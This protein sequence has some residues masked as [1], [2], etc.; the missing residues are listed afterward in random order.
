ML[1]LPALVVSFALAVAAARPPVVAADAQRYGRGVTTYIRFPGY[2]HFFSGRD[3]RLTAEDRIWTGRMLDFEGANNRDEAILLLW[4]MIQR[5][6][7]G[8]GPYT[9]DNPRPD[10][11]GSKGWTEFIRMFSQPI[12]PAW[13]RDGYKCRRPGGTAVNDPGCSEQK[14]QRRARIARTS[15]NELKPF[16]RE[17]TDLFMA[18]R[19]PRPPSV[20]GVVNWDDG[21]GRALPHQATFPFRTGNR[22][23]YNATGISKDSPILL[24][25]RFVVNG[26]EVIPSADVPP[27]PIS[28]NLLLRMVPGGVDAF[29]SV[30]FNFARK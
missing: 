9:R 10:A 19:L 27:A 29:D 18:G 3:L 26:E 5:K 17:V 25:I 1:R 15:F 12:N 21:G 24:D 23:F 6:Y 16:V 2:R 13:Y 20:V 7:W 22:Y 11:F 30:I 8:V 4:A 28:Q 14:L